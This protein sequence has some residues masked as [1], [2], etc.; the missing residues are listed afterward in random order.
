[1]QEISEIRVYLSKSKIFGFILI[2]VFFMCL[3]PLIAKAVHWDNISWVDIKPLLG[4][5]LGGPL[6]SACL[7]FLAKLLFDKREWLKVNAK[8]ITWLPVSDK[9]IQWEE[10]V[11]IG[12]RKFKRS[13][14]MIIFLKDDR[15][16]A[17]KGWKKFLRTKWDG[18]SFLL[19]TGLLDIG[20]EDLKS[21]V[22]KQ[23]LLNKSKPQDNFRNLDF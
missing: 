11:S 2:C 17:K 21:F 16:F 7:L 18:N 9:M 6:F 8:G 12:E 1:M 14:S 4:L 5:V 10:I 3:L 19:N 23:W 20:Y 15:I 13:R 22:D